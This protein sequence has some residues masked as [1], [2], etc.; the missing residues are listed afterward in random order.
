MN[1]LHLQSARCSVHCAWI[2]TAI[3]ALLLAA[4]SQANSQNPEM[5]PV[6]P[7]PG[8]VRTFFL[9]NVSNQNDINDI[10]TDLRNVLPRTKIYGIATENAITLRG[11]P[12]E[13]ETAQK[14]IAELDRPK[15]IYRVTYTITELD[16]GKRLTARN[17]SVL[18]SDY[19]KGILKQGTKVPIA[20]GASGSSS[21]VT[22][23]FQYVDVGLNLE[24]SAYGSELRTK[25]EQSSVA[26]EKSSV[27]PQ[28]PVVRQTSLEGTSPLA[29]GK[30]VVLGAMDI[31]GTTHQQQISVTT[32]LLPQQE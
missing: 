25:I 22:T 7:E 27:G 4:A 14:L 26:D 11:T 15:K 30:S 3:A 5:R 2:S 6:P 17:I 31:P 9:K 13:L 12:E 19:G 24:A 1:L 28:D 21:D 10:Q 20:T 23:Q 8:Q 16:G 29:A 18:V 32:E